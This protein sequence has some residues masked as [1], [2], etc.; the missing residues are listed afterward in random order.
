[1]TCSDTAKKILSTT[2]T[3]TYGTCTAANAACST[4]TDAKVTISGII[5][6]CYP[7]AK[8][9]V[10]ET[11]TTY[12]NT[13]ATNFYASIDA[14]LTDCIACAS[15]AQTLIVTGATATSGYC[16]DKTTSATTNICGTAGK[17]MSL[18]LMTGGGL[19]TAGSFCVAAGPTNTG[20]CAVC[21]TGTVRCAKYVYKTAE[22]SLVSE[23]DN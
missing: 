4:N 8:T 5:Y 1:M 20:K 2:S 21:T 11:C 15:S 13:F 19:E 18:T 9:G 6:Y 23:P 3:G 16:V 7:P 10:K 17:W 12:K 14:V 22:F